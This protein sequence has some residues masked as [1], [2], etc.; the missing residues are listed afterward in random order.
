MFELKDKPKPNDKIY[1][2]NDEL[3]RLH[4]GER[5]AYYALKYGVQL[6][7][8]EY[9]AIVN[10]DKEND[11]KMAKYFSSILTQIIKNGFELAIMEEKNGKK[12]QSTIIS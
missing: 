10:I 5:S 12:Q 4:I 6:T 11:D 9:Q 8:E 2:F 1:D 3:V 7:E